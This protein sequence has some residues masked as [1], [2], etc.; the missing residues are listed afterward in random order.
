MDNRVKDIIFTS[1]VIST[2]RS[3]YQTYFIYLMNFFLERT[4]FPPFLERVS[5][6]GVVWGLVGGAKSFKG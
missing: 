6:R 4:P 5:T 2:S 3:K 1:T